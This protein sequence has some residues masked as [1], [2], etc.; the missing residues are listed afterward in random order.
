MKKLFLSILVLL[1]IL[2]IQ[3]CLEDDQFGKNQDEDTTV[4]PK[5]DPFS[6]PDISPFEEPKATPPSAQQIE[7]IKNLAQVSFSFDKGF[8][9]I[10]DKNSIW[11]FRTNEKEDYYQRGSLKISK[12]HISNH[13]DQDLNIRLESLVLKGKLRQYLNR[14]LMKSTSSLSSLQ[15]FHTTQP[16]EIDISNYMTI[17]F[18]NGYAFSTDQATY[19]LRKGETLFGFLTVYFSNVPTCYLHADKSW[20]ENGWGYYASFSV[21]RIQMDYEMSFEISKS[22]ADMHDAF[23]EHSTAWVTDYTL[24]PEKFSIQSDLS[25]EMVESLYEFNVNDELITALDEDLE[26]FSCNGLYINSHREEQ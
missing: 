11:E 7:S 16:K 5:N 8:E 21:L 18:E 13:S 12:F 9:S 2:N 3:G 4:F 20:N 15:L 14:F 22:L 6:P 23:Y 25:N 1:F 26:E 10:N 19:T 17:S 24:S